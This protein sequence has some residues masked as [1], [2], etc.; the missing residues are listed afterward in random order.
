MGA[1]WWMR[2]C[3]WVIEILLYQPT[4]LDSQL[5][6]YDSL[7][8]QGSSIKGGSI[9][10]GAQTPRK[11]CPLFKRTLNIPAPRPH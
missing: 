2:S 7:Y 6:Q 8:S 5:K 3:D 4:E 11:R 1:N 9:E 10:N